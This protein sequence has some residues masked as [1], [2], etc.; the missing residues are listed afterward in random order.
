MKRHLLLLALIALL[1]PL[2]VGCTRVSSPM[3]NTPQLDRY[4]SIEEGTRTQKVQQLQG[5]WQYMRAE[6]HERPLEDE[7][8]K[9]LRLTFS[10]KNKVVVQVRDD[11]HNGTF[12]LG[13]PNEIDIKPAPGNTK[14]KPM[15]GICE[16]TGDRMKVCFSQQ[17][18]PAR[19]ETKAGTDCILIYFMRPGSLH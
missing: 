10:D 7:D 8:T 2:V 1:A 4:Q 16:V 15:Y 5:D 17:D 3:T 19:F 9:S 6:M 18:R 13:K 12:E 14:D 11:Q